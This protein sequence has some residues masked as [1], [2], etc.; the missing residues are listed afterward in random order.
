M[1][2]I[3]LFFIICMSIPMLLSSIYIAIYIAI[4]V[5]IEILFYA[6]QRLKG[7]K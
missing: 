3:D 6:I 7:L 5:S 2:T 1:K 4:Y